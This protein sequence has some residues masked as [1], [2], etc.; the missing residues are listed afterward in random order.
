MVA[1]GFV[2]PRGLFVISAVLIGL[3]LLLALLVLR[4]PSRVAKEHSDPAGLWP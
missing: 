2:S 4:E 1:I 3:N